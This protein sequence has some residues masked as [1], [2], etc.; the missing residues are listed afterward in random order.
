MLHRAE[1]VNRDT[2]EFLVVHQIM[3][4]GS[5]TEHVAVDNFKKDISANVINN[6][7]SMLD[8]VRKNPPAKPHIKVK[9]TT[10][11]HR[12]GRVVRG[13]NIVAYPAR[14]KEEVA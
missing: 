8:R 10:P 6:V 7:T 1:N 13:Y 3:A 11:E 4:D 5:I 2:V 14:T 9:N 12:P